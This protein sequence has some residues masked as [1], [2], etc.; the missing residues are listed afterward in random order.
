MS[1]YGSYDMVLL[2]SQCDSNDGRRPAWWRR[3]QRRLPPVVEEEHLGL[4]RHPPRR[5]RRRRDNRG[6]AEGD[7]SS[8]V[9]PERVNDAG[10]PAGDMSGVVLAPETMTGVASLQRASPKQTDDASTLAKDLLGVSLVPEIMVHS[11]PDATL[12][13]SINQEVPSIFHPVPFKFSFDPPSD[14]ASVS[15]FAR[16]YPDLP[17]YHM[18]SSW[19]R[20]T[21]VST[22]GP[23]GSEEDDDPD[24][25]WDFS[26][27]HD[28]SAMRD[29]MSACDYC[30]SGCSDDDHSL[31]DEGYD[32]SRECFHIDQGD[33]GEDNHLGM[34]EDEN[35]PVSTSRVDIPR[36]L[37]VVPVPA[38]GQ[39]T[40]LEQFR[41]MQAKLDEEAEQLVQ[42][43]QNIEQ[44]WV[45]RALAGGARHRA[46]D[47]QRRIVDDARAGLP[48]AFS[49]AG[50]NL[51]T[52]AMLLRTMSEP[53]TTEGRRIQG[54]LKNLL[55]D[56]TVR[57]AES[58]ASRRHGCPSEHR[59]MPSRCIREA[60][61]RTERT[62]DGTPAAPD[63]LGDEQHRRDRRA[64][65]EERVRR[66]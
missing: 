11:V 56:A 59:A 7:T 22:S 12:P 60:T 24:F 15:A 46:R 35:A 37:A 63:R 23:V 38:G 9:G 25:G 19:Y 57:R 29:F 45:G 39:D 6:Q 53:S 41:E 65:L 8:V 50:Q 16:A 3:T 27:L 31:D 4:P 42:L 10:T 14:P 55:E 44:E 2:P 30:L 1:R 21:V 32:L 51:A 17:G 40:Q 61:V 5:R 62:R 58:S 13:P 33:H 36:E 49:G 20:L 47:I 18:W 34:P 43:R 54:E 52:A 64:R 66:G 28:P 48:P 26:G